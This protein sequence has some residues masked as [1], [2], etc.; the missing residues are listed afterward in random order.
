M[1]AQGVLSFI[2]L[3]I[4]VNIYLYLDSIKDCKCFV[5]NE[6]GESE[7]DVEFLKF[8][9]ILEIVSLFIFLSFVYMYKTNMN[10]GKGK[11]SGV[12]LFMT[13]SLFILMFISGYISYNSFLFYQ[14]VNKHCNCA[15]KW[16]Q[17]FI[18]LQGIFNSV[19]FLRLCFTFILVLLMIL[20]GFN[21]GF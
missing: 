1:Y 16:Q 10:G 13:L 20:S 11:N 9:Q 12:M 21:L 8:Y 15:N 19:Y 14:N 18:Y 17:Y 4:L 5:S 6:N 7:V 3:V 2:S